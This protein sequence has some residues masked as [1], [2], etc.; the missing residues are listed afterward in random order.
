MLIYD[1][2]VQAR[3]FELVEVQYELSQLV[4]A[5]VADSQLLYA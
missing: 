4:N 2:D 5:F 1:V 3:R